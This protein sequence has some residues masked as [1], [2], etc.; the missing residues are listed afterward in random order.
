M[1]VPNPMIDPATGMAPGQPFQPYTEQTSGWQSNAEGERIDQK[2]KTPEYVEAQKQAAE[3][4]DARVAAAQKQGDANIQLEQIER[5]NAE[6]AQRIAEEEAIRR[7]QQQ[8]ADNDRIAA[9]HAAEDAKRTEM[10]KAGK[11][12]SYWEDRSAPARIFSA[13]ILGLAEGANRQAGPSSALQ[14][15]QNQVAED[16]QAKLDRL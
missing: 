5:D 15:Y 9:L 13:I 11:I 3:A 7:A 8:K 10:E 16:R 12:T 2:R 4:A 6:K 14:V 1:S